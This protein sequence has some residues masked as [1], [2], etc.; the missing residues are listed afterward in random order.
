[1]QGA[2]VFAALPKGRVEAEPSSDHRCRGDRF[3]RSREA[4]YTA[5]MSWRQTIIFKLRH[6]PGSPS[7]LRPTSLRFL[8]TS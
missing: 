1:M 7:P 5:S 3:F 2:F 4:S 6:D 8:L